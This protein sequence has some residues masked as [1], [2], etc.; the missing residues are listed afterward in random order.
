VRGFRHVHDRPRAAGAVAGLGVRRRRNGPGSLSPCRRITRTPRPARSPTRWSSRP[1][2]RYLAGVG[3][4]SQSGPWFPGRGVLCLL[5]LRFCRCGV[6]VGVGGVGGWCAAGFGGVRVAVRRCGGRLAGRG[7]GG[8]STGVA[9][10]NQVVN[11]LSYWIPPPSRGLQGLHSPNRLVGR[12]SASS[13]W[14]SCLPSS[15]R[16]R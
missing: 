6:P 2:R 16:G 15:A 9:P 14:R 12:A 7:G 3:P 11:P 1:S 8:A 10:A 5:S 4:V 13:S